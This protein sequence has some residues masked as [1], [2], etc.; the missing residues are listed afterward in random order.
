MAPDV[1]GKVDKAAVP[2]HFSI[3]G[4]RIKLP[5]L[6]FK[7]NLPKLRYTNG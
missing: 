7:D 1:M 6:T 5:I 3:N 4:T 2:E